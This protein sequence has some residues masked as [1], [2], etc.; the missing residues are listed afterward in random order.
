MIHYTAMQEYVKKSITNYQNSV[1]D[2][3]TLM[4]YIQALDS[5]RFKTPEEILL[6]FGWVKIIARRIESFLIHNFV[7]YFNPEYDLRIDLYFDNKNDKLKWIDWFFEGSKP[8]RL[9]H[10]DVKT[11]VADNNTFESIIHI[12][13]CAWTLYSILKYNGNL[14]AAVFNWYEQSYFPEDI[15]K[16]A[17]NEVNRNHLEYAPPPPPKTLEKLSEHKIQ[18]PVVDNTTKQVVVMGRKLK[19][20]KGQVDNLVRNASFSAI[21]HTEAKIYNQADKLDS[22]EYSKAQ[23][24]VKADCESQGY[25]NKSGIP[26]GYHKENLNVPPNQLIYY[27]GETHLITIAPTGSG[28][29][30]SVQI[31]TLLEYTGSIVVLD[32]KGEAAIISARQRQRLGQE[33]CI[34]NPFEILKSEFEGIGF[35]MFHGFNPLALLDVNDDNFVADVTAIAEALVLDDN[36]NSDPY[37]NDS[38]RD[39]ISCLIMCVCICEP[40]QN[41]HLPRVRE[42]LTQPLEAFTETMIKISKHDFKPMAQ[43]TSRYITEGNASVPSIISTAMTHTLFLDDPRIAANLQQNDFNFRDLKTSKKTIYLILPAKFLLAY[44]RWLRLLITSALDTLMSTHNKPEKSVLFMLDEFAVLGNLSCIETAIGLARG[45]GIQLWLFLQDIHQLHHL[46]KDKAESFLANTGMQQYFIPN[47]LTTAERISK[48][49]GCTTLIEEKITSDIFRTHSMIPNNTQPLKIEISHK[50]RP[51]LYP[52]E[53]MALDKDVQL[54][55]FAGNA[56][57]IL[58]TKNFYYQ[59]S[60]YTGK[61]DKNPYV[62]ESQIL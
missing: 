54:V 23:Y 31:P 32:P 60:G 1:Q 24:A 20:L 56:N 58:M 22:Q 8:I 42:L 26:I 25:F 15:K 48:R 33:V 49:M 2:N 16:A 43:K 6:K 53:I 7:S 35:K 62:K 37:W 28:K 9:I 40:E 55:F 10:N 59:N 17:K 52:I 57:P 46:Y 51:L 21:E 45:Y 29:L 5:N 19:D 36:G 34:I 4:D 12:R 47:D 18:P 38:A 3:P 61:Y 44:N 41:K 50:E 11:S 13:I 14:D 39:L 27:Q 30:T